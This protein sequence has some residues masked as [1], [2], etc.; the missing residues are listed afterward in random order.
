MDKE[1][2]Q[3]EPEKKEETEDEEKKEVITKEL[4][5]KE[6]PSIE[7]STRDKVIKAIRDHGFD[8]EDILWVAS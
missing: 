2:V 7:L 5:F 8:R 1:P 3:V 4:V 6:Y